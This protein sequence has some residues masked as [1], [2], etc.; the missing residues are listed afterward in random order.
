MVWIH[1][2]DRARR[3]HRKQLQTS[4]IRTI[5]LYRNKGEMTAKEQ[6]RIL[7][8]VLPQFLNRQIERPAVR[9]Y[10]TTAVNNLSRPSFRP[11]QV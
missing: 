9:H 2:D 7:S 8:F 3:H 5:W 4:G 10:K 6:L 1:A 11:T